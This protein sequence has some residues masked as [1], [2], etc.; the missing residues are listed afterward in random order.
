MQALTHTCYLY[1]PRP[2]SGQYSV[3]ARSDLEPVMPPDFTEEPAAF[4]PAVTDA[5]A[6][7]WAL[8]VHRLWAQLCWKARASLYGHFC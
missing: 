2:W 7:A 4:L 5:G 6:R 8:A 1:L 3:E